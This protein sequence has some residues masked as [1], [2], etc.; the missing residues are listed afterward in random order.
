MFPWVTANY[1]GISHPMWILVPLMVASLIIYSKFSVKKL[2][3]DFHWTVWDTL[4]LSFVGIVAINLIFSEIENKERIVRYLFSIMLFPYFF[5]RTISRGGIKIFV[6]TTLIFSFGFTIFTLISIVDLGNLTLGQERVYL[7]SNFPAHQA[8]PLGMA[9]LAIFL[10][11]SLMLENQ[12]NPKINR[13]MLI[14]LFGAILTIVFLGSRAVLTACL[15]AS[16]ATVFLA[17]WKEFK[18]K[19]LCLSVITCAVIVALAIVPQDK[20]WFFGQ[21]LNINGT[22][23]AVHKIVSNVE[24]N[25][26]P[27]KAGGCN[28]KDNSMA[29]R[30]VLYHEAITAFI[31]NPIVGVGVGRFGY[32][33]CF[34]GFR[35]ELNSPHS[36]VLHALVE[37]GLIGGGLFL[38]L[39]VGLIFWLLPQMAKEPNLGTRWGYIISPMFLFSAILDQI[40]ASYITS[41]HYYL[42]AGILVKLREQLHDQ[43]A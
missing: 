42:L 23:N 16:V 11:S 13:I 33:S 8:F 4:F 26:L 17:R 27:A 34:Y 37:L 14:V 6:Y 30:I 31:Q 21:L 25:V 22:I 36:T 19:L 38:W 29:N 18:T 41:V 32:Y 28:V 39:M 1:S 20:K 43:Q 10:V 2:L 35:G 7:Y 3:A 12:D 40:S 5:S 9:L 15:F 24:P